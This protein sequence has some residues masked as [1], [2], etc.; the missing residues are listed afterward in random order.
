MVEAGHGLSAVAKR[1]NEERVPTVGRAAHW[2]RGFVYKIVKGR[3]AVGEFQMYTQRAD[4]PRKP[5]GARAVSKQSHARRS[6][7]FAM[8]S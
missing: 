6:W 4:G 5:D 7:A 3:A 1:L 2:D 8:M